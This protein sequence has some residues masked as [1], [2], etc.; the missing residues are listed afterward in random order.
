MIVNWI[1]RNYQILKEAVVDLD[2]L[3]FEFELSN[4]IRTPSP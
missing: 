2:L 4:Y 1:T 3:V